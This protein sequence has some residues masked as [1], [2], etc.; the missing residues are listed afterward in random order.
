MGGGLAAQ[1]RQQYPKVYEEYKAWV[2]HNN[3]NPKHLLGDV[4]FCYLNEHADIAN[5]FGQENVGVGVRQTDYD[6][7]KKAFAKVHDYI[8]QV[9]SGGAFRMNKIAIPKYFG[10]GLAGGDWNIVREIIVSA[11]EDLDIDLII[12][13]YSNE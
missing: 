6:A 8:N 3:K 10:C 12:V 11:L 5:V 13:E 4:L 7:L 2:N 9:Q 1:V